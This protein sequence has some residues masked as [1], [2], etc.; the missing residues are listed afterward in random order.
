MEHLFE[1]LAQDIEISVESMKTEIDYISDD[2]I[3]K[4]DKIEEN[5]KKK[6]RKREKN[7]RKLVTNFEKSKNIF[8]KMNSINKF[9]NLRFI[10]SDLNISSN[11]LI[12]KLNGLDISD[13]VYINEIK[14]SE[15]KTIK[16][17]FHPYD[18]CNCFDEQLAV[19]DYM[20]NKVHLFDKKFQKIKSISSINNEY[21]N[22]PRGIC[23]ENISNNIYLCDTL[24]QRILIINK[25]FSELKQIIKNFN[26]IKKPQS[27]CFNGK[28]LFILDTQEIVNFSLNGDYINKFSLNQSNVNN[29]AELK[30]IKNPLCMKL[31]DNCKLAIN[32]NRE[33]VFIYNLKGDID[34]TIEFEYEI[35]ALFYSIGFLFIHQYNGTL[36]CY[37]NN[38]HNEW[39]SIFERFVD[40][41]ESYSSTDFNKHLVFTQ[42][43][44]N[45]SVI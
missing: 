11:I 40:F 24:N 17:K 28:S 39:L 29:N 25:E 12:G 16:L 21:F 9:P 31:V 3:E 41:N 34:S 32:I 37:K 7:L 2:L 44:S 27:I 22:S 1:F 8:I 5:Y 43:D 20:N 18:L 26:H 4:M 13:S 19:T 14:V 30:L 15:I 42:C 38:E 45:I 36:A 33:K 10:E 35:G 23:I 6:M